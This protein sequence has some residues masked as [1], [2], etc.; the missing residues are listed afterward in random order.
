MLLFDVKRGKIAKFC[1]MILKF[2]ARIRVFK[3]L[4]LIKL[5]ILKGMTFIWRCDGKPLPLQSEMEVEMK[6]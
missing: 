1:A 6:N 4:R 3:G 2:F 5:I